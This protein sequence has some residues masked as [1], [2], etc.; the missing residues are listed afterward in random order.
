MRQ[1]RKVPVELGQSQVR[2]TGLSTGGH[3]LT[4]NIGPLGATQCSNHT[5][6]HSPKSGLA[7]KAPAKSERFQAALLWFGLGFL[8]LFP[9]APWAPDLKSRAQSSL[10]FRM[11]Q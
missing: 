4:S 11:S 5:V 7:G 9:I 6:T 2:S 8:L 3:V 1:Y 10:L